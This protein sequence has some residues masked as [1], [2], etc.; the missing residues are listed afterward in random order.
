MRPR[1]RNGTR[2]LGMS[3][4]GEIAEPPWPPLQPN[5][6]ACQSVARSCRIRPWN[7][8][9]HGLYKAA[10]S[11]RRLPDQPMHSDSL[12]QWTHD[13][14]FLGPKHA[15]NERRTWLVVALTVVMMVGEIAAGSL[16]GTLALL[17]HGWHIATHAA[18]LRDAAAPFLLSRQPRL[19]SLFSLRTGQYG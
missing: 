12:D 10:E 14:V 18:A 15:R 2:Y 7:V 6:P 3:P 17:A 5:R 11:Q 16:F 4:R 9:P 8:G 1:I 13:H 19:N